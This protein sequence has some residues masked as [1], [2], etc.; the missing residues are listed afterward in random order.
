MGES[1]FVF[2]W[3]A[4]AI[5]L[6]LSSIALIYSVFMVPEP[7]Y[8][9]KYTLFIA[10]PWIIGLVQLSGLSLVFF[11]LM[12]VSTVFASIIIL[13]LADGYRGMRILHSSTTKIRQPDMWCSNY[14]AIFPRLLSISLFIPTAFYALVSVFDSSPV[15]PGISDYPLWA[16]MF[17]LVFAS[18]WEEF[19]FR[20]FFIAVPLYV[21]HK[22]YG[23]EKKEY[24]E[25]GSSVGQVRGSGCREIIWG[26][27]SMTREAVYLVLFTAFIFAAAHAFG[28]WDWYKVPPTFFTGAALGYVFIKRGLPGAVILHFAINF[29]STPMWIW[30]SG[31][32]IV[33]TLFLVLLACGAYYSLVYTIVLSRRLKKLWKEKNTRRPLAAL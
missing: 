15:I 9:S 32:W 7:L 2:S 1:S 20:I 13:V 26:Y 28:G 18:V 27:G 25:T 22:I 14:W 10:V 4:A 17:S 23:V 24:G 5:S 16:R 31:S 29:F 6:A 12:V 11:Y 21:L 30:S 33:V 3:T 8:S 19:I